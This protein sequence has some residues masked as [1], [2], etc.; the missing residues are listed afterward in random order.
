MYVVVIVDYADMEA[1]G[2]IHMV[3]I[4]SL[5]FR[6]WRCYFFLKMKMRTV[7]FSRVSRVEKSYFIF[8]E[9]YEG[10]LVH[11]RQ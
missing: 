10:E 6:S 4:M 3:A 9:T 8:V 7:T 11:Y 1:N 5:C 2:I